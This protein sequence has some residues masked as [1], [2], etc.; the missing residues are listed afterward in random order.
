MADPAQRSHFTLASLPSL[1]LMA[2]F[3][4]APFSPFTM[5]LSPRLVNG[6]GGSC[7]T[8]Y[9]CAFPQRPPPAFLLGKGL[10]TTCKSAYYSQSDVYRRTFQTPWSHPGAWLTACMAEAEIGLRAGVRAVPG[11]HCQVPPCRVRP[12]NTRSTPGESTGTPKEAGKS[13]HRCC[14]SPSGVLAQDLSSLP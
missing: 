2:G 3:P 4:K 14:P 1:M 10:L 11:H 8:V 13:R 12:P 7:G 6:F 5:C 9:C